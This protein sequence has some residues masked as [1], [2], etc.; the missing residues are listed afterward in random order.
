MSQPPSKPAPLSFVPPTPAPQY[1]PTWRLDLCL[2][3]FDPDFA[4]PRDAGQ[5][6]SFPVST[7]LVRIGGVSPTRGSLGLFPPPILRRLGTRGLFVRELRKLLQPPG[8]TR[9][10]PAGS[11]VASLSRVTSW[12]RPAIAMSAI[13]SGLGAASFPGGEEPPAYS[14]TSAVLDGDELDAFVLEQGEDPRNVLGATT[15]V[16]PRTPTPSP[17]PVPPRVPSPIP[18][19]PAASS[20]PL[21]GAGE[22]M[23]VDED[24]IL[25]PP[26]SPP[27]SPFKKIPLRKRH[28]ARV[29]F[30]EDEE[31]VRPQV[32]R[33]RSPAGRV[34]PPHIPS[35]GSWE[36]SRPRRLP[37]ASSS[38]RYP[39]R[40]PPP[41]S[42]AHP[43][44]QPRWFPSEARRSKSP[45]RKRM[46]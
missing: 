32:R 30:E 35:A 9:I 13:T 1:S 45:A 26:A 5:P 38:C 17:S 14:F 44:R 11:W 43:P 42:R 25:L 15:P 7:F 29:A 21:A 18:A 2:T 12:S 31:D 40:S 39:R 36:N 28:G 4:L 19:Y 46:K 10:W 37:A 24:F 3:D 16:P 33:S 8:I 34:P 41:S 23:D 27:P 22:E 20:E 6:T